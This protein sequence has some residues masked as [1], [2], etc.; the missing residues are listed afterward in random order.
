MVRLDEIFYICYGNGLELI[1]CEESENGIPFISRTSSNNGVVGRV[2]IK[3]EVEPMPAFAITVALGGSVLSSFFQSEMFYTSFHIFCLYPKFQLTE[4]QMLYY[5]TIIE[6][7]KYRYNYG[8]QANKTLK[9]ILVPSIDEIKT[10]IE[11][12]D[13]DYYFPKKPLLEMKISL[14]TDTWMSFK[15]KDIFNIHTSNDKN[16]ESSED[17]LTPYIS[18][19]QVN[20]GISSYVANEATQKGNT[21]T[22][23]RNGSIGA[24]FYHSYAYCVSPD[25]VRVF[26]PKFSFNKYIAIFISVL[27]ER[28]KYRF[29]YGRKFGTKRMMDTELKLPVLENGQPDWQFMEDY[30][31]SLPYSANL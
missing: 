12:I 15:L 10:N 5:C 6:K 25:D 7:N 1:N 16:L 21:L 26:D 27:I 4:M 20:N 9:E 28:E 22:V 13:V 29:A 18:A 17:G 11:S 8:R 14:K 2:K 19:S 24:T 30:I 3:D 23:A 31:K